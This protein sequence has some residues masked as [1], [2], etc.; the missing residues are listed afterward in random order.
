[1]RFSASKV[2]GSVLGRRDGLGE[3]RRTE[4]FTLRMNTS[5]ARSSMR[6]RR[7]L[8]DR[9]ASRAVAAGR[10]KGVGT[11]GQIVTV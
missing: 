9:A 1:M 6:L 2:V 10:E 8:G 5:V 11:V 7:V 4:E 3:L